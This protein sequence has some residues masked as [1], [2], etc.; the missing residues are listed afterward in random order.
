MGKQHLI[1]KEKMHAI[2]RNVAA[3][4]DPIPLTESEVTFVSQPTD[5]ELLNEIMDEGEEEEEEDKSPSIHEDTPLKR[6]NVSIASTA[7][8]PDIYRKLLPEI[9]RIELVLASTRFYYTLQ[10]FF[11]LYGTVPFGRDDDSFWW[12]IQNNYTP[13]NIFQRTPFDINLT[14]AEYAAEMARRMQEEADRHKAQ[15]EAQAEAEALAA[16]AEAAQAKPT[17]AKPEE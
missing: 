10:E 7:L 6:S 15:Q 9:Q 12:P 8:P 14:F 2:C 1:I 4:L 13:P 3:S 17:K 16:E 11:D 5:S